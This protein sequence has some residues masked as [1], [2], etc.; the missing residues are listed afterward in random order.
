MY[1]LKNKRE[2][3]MMVKTKALI[4][5]ILS[6]DFVLITIPNGGRSKQFWNTNKLNQMLSSIY[7]L[8]EVFEKR[9]RG[10]N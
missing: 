7:N 6:K 9:I 5:L 1:I 8:V 10:D 3:A 4:S 2:G